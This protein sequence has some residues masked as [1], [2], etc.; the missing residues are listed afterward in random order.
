MNTGNKVTLSGIVTWLI[1]TFFFM[2]EFVLRTLLGTFQS[3]MMHDLQLT[4]VQFAFLSTTVFQLIYGIMQ[5]PVGILTDWFG[6]K[7]ILL[8]ASI[9]CAI[10][11]L[12]FSMSNHYVAVT[13]FRMLM[14]LG[15]S[16]GFICLLI[17]IYDWMPQKN[18]CLFIGISQFIGTIGPMFAAGP[19][20]TLLYQSNISWRDVFL[21]LALI[22]VVITIFVFRFVENNRRQSDKFIILSH[23]T[24]LVD[25]LIYLIKKKQIWCIAIYSAFIYFSIEYLTENEGVAFLVEKGFSST[26]SSYMITLVWLGFAASCPLT[27]YFSDKIQRRKPFMIVSSILVL[28]SL[29]GI[30]Y[31]PLNQAGLSI[32]FCLLGIGAGGSS[33]GFAIMAEQCK[34]NSLAAGL[35]INNTLIVITSSLLAPLIGFVL[36]YTSSGGTVRLINYQEAFG[37]MVYI[38][39]IAVTV[40]FFGIKETF[41]KSTC[42]NTILDAKKSQIMD[43]ILIT[44]QSQH[45]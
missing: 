10:A 35:A 38:A 1:C 41:C 3:P 40:V 2:Y 33:I 16:C 26:F 19:L 21:N 15:A 6:L 34:E 42:S 30:I 11:N 14:G 4:P 20:N 28:L 45:D 23:S 9:I 37:S 5:I 18:T 17:A 36:S 39:I 31:L 22:G 27:G 44:E 13:L 43:D 29:F 8:G 7:K 12:G 25:D 32:G 24:S